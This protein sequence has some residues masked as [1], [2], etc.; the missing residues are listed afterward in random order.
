VSSDYRLAAGLLVRGLGL[1]IASAGLV[2]VVVGILVGVLGLPHLVLTSAVVVAALLVVGLAV[3]GLWIQRRVSL[4]RFDEVG[5]RVR[6]VRG[7][8]TKQA[9]WRDIEDVVTARA[10]GTDVV[11]VRLRNGSTSTVPVAALAVDPTL[12]VQELR[13]HLD[14]A[15]GYRRLP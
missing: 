6:L 14:R 15:H 3:G 7:V 12:F 9:R 8:G 1:L 5:Y 11:V 2:L 4:V 10:R 13:S